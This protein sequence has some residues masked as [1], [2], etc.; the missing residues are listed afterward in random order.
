[1]VMTG[2]GVQVVTGPAWRSGLSWAHG[3]SAG[4]FLLA[5]LGHL[6]IPHDRTAEVGER[7]LEIDP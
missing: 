1:M 4:V 3:I 5:Y 7:R 6:L 2:Y